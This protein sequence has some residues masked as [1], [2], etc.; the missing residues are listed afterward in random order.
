MEFIRQCSFK[1][2]IVNKIDIENRLELYN[3]AEEEI[4][5]E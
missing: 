1:G 2:W 3:I 4:K 5:F